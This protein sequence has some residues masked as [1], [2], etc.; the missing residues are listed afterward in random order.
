VGELYIGGAGLAQGYF[1]RPDLTAEKF[2]AHPFNDDPTARLYKTGDLARYRPD[3]TIEFLGRADHQV[4]IRGYRIELGEIEAALSQHP[5]IQ[6][7]IVVTS[8]KSDQPPGISDDPESLYQ[9]LLAHSPDEI[10]RL[11]NTVERL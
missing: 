2:I 5:E 4:K 9:A 6:D 3:G 10:E 11:L 8:G 7:V 1:N